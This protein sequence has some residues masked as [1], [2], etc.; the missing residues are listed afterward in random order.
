MSE[1]S[2]PRWA[3]YSDF[4]ENLG[5]FSE[6]YEELEAQFLYLQL[7]FSNFYDKLIEENKKDA[8]VKILKADQILTKYSQ[9]T[10]E[11]FEKQVRAS[12]EMKQLLHDQKIQSRAREEAIQAKNE[13]LSVHQIR[14][15]NLG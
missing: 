12:K 2:T 11:I 8:L 1:S 9:T 14:R 5:R 6:F 7:N 3:D 4:L 13:F 15:F 10:L